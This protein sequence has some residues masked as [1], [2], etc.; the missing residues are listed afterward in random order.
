MS[1]VHTENHGEGS[2]GSFASYIVGFVLAAILTLAAFAL[3]DM[4]YFSPV[5]T[6]GLLAGL[7]V[8]QIVVHLRYFLHM[9][10][11]SSQSWN[12]TAFGFAVVCLAII[13]GG[14]LFIMHDVSMNMMSR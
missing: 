5:L 6:I 10:L 2:H 1:Q 14:T 12:N 8:V 3:A 7:A 4:R 9:N 13:V 11:N